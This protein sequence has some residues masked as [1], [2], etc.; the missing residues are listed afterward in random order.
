I[1]KDHISSSYQRMM[2]TS[3]DK[4]YN[5]AIPIE[6][7]CFVNTQMYAHTF[8]KQ[9]PFVGSISVFPLRVITPMLR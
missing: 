8:G 4:F 6:G 5:S 7:R 2:V 3:I 1:R 9:E